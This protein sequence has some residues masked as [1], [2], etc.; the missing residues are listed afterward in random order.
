MRDYLHASSVE[1]DERNI[2]H[3][4][5]ARADLQSRT[6]SLLVPVLMYQE[7]S[8]IGFD[9]EGIDRIVKAYRSGK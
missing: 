6:G 5:D 9:P 1:F 8:V 4:E 2:R 7:E 3:S